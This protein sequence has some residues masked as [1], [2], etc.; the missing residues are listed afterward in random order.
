MN[1]VVRPPID[2]S[3]IFRPPCLQRHSLFAPPLLWGLGGMVEHFFAIE[4]FFGRTNLLVEEKN[5]VEIFCLVHKK[6]LSKFFSTNVIIFSLSPL[7]GLFTFL[8]EGG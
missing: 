7:S 3:G 5:L 4:H 1:P 6:F 2:V 8:P